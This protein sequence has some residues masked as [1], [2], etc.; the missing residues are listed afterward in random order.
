MFAGEISDMPAGWDVSGNFVT[1][2]VRAT[3]VLARLSKGKALQS[4]FRRGYLRDLT[5]APLIYWPCEEKVSSTYFAPAIGIYPMWITNGAPTLANS[6]DF[7]CSDALPTL[8]FSAWWAQIPPYTPGSNTCQVRFLVSIPTGGLGL[9]QRRMCLITFAGGSV[10][11]ISCFVDQSGNVAINVYDTNLTAIHIGASVAGN[12]NGIPHQIAI[13]FQQN[14]ATLVK[15]NVITLG[16]GDS[17]IVELGTTNVAGSQTLGIATS[18]TVDPDVLMTDSVAMGHYS[19]HTTNQSILALSSQLNAWR[20][21]TAGARLSR[22]TTEERLPFSYIGTLSDSEPMGPQ[23]VIEL[24]KL[25]YECQHADMGELFESRGEPGVTYRPRSNLHNQTAAI[26]LDYSLGQ[27]NEPFRSTD[28]DQYLKNDITVTRPNGGNWRATL[29]TGRL[30]TLPPE[31][32]G[33][34]RYDDTR[35]VNVYDDTQLPDIAGWL[36]S[37][38]TVAESRYPT[39]V[40]D[41]GNLHLT[42]A[43]F[44]DAVLDLDV[45]DR[46]VITN[47]KSGQQV[48]SISQLIVGMSV[49]MN[50]WQFVVTFNCIPESPFQV[51]VL[52]DTDKRLDSDYT[53]LTSDITSSATSFTVTIAT[54]RAL[55]TTAAG[56]LPISVTIGGEQMSIGAVSGASSPQTFSSVTRSVNGVVKAQNAGAEVHVTYPFRLA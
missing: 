2:E 7:E 44:Q 5:T 52:S 20:S 14:T 3:G 49:I 46:I 45:G 53:T 12:L 56:D 21:E 36:L 17:A 34:G 41:L 24:Q 42:S 51:G 9:G 50:Q 16:E 55:W 35:T 39:I 13:E 47:P 48:G 32:G 25:M 40:L 38:G 15:I 10:G 27:I 29:E 33:S 18:I 19:F 31:L 30:S 28:D 11:N 6:T 54:G 4:A 43:G 1:A 22:L 8:N 37:Q 23:L 26:T